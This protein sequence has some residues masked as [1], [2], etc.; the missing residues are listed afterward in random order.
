MDGVNNVLGRESQSY[1]K[2]SL[3]DKIAGMGTHDVHSQDFAIA[4]MA[5]QLDQASCLS[6]GH[7]TATG[8]KGKL[9]HPVVNAAIAGF[10]LGDAGTGYLRVAED[11]IG[12]SV[13]IGPARTT[14]GILNS[15]LS[16]IRGNMSQHVLAQNIADGINIFDVRLKVFID[17]D[18]S[19]IR[20]YAEF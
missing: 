8:G 10:L 9:A 11:A 20:L 13:I 16:L 1:G 18:G 4:R 19:P 2:R 3:R 5:N 15:Y 6:H 17:S 14:K 12:D 7:S